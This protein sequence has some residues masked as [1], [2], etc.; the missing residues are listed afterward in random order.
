PHKIGLKSIVYLKKV[1]KYLRIGR[2]RKNKKV[3]KS[4]NSGFKEFPRPLILDLGG[5]AEKRIRLGRVLGRDW[6]PGWE[7]G[8]CRCR[9]YRALRGAQDKNVR[10]GFHF[11][12]SPLH[13]IKC[14]CKNPFPIPAPNPFPAP[15]PAG[16]AFQHGQPLRKCGM[17]R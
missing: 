14:T 9:L 4:G 13:G 16:Y 15:A 7:R 8:F 12:W 6:G 17:E 2:K 3:K 11:F 1:E 5:G 10:W